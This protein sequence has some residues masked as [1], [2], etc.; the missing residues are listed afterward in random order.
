MDLDVSIRRSFK[1]R[2]VFKQ[3]TLIDGGSTLCVINRTLAEQLISLSV[4]LLEI[5]EGRA[6]MVE[7]G[8]AK[9]VEY[10]GHYITIPTKHPAQPRRWVPLRYYIPPVDLCIPIIIGDSARRKLGMATFVKLDRIEE[11]M[12]DDEKGND[13]DTVRTKVSIVPMD[14]AKI[15]LKFDHHADRE[16]MGLD[17]KLD[18]SLLD[19]MSTGNRQRAQQPLPS[20]DLQ[21]EDDWIVNHA[22]GAEL[23]DLSELN[24]KS[25]ATHVREEMKDVLKAVFEDYGL[26]AANRF[27]DI[28]LN[29]YACLSEHKFDFGTFKGI[30][31]SIPMKKEWNGQPMHRRPYNSHSPED[32]RWAK[33]WCEQLVELGILEPY[34][35]PWGQPGFV[36]TNNDGSKRL[37]I[38]YGPVNQMTQP[39][40]YPCPDINQVVLG[41]QGM[42]C[43]SQFDICK[44]FYN[45]ETE[46]EDKEK[47]AFVM[48]FGAYVWNVMSLGGSRPPATWAMQLT[49]LSEECPELPSTLTT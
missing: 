10:D 41:F 1:D 31:Y 2:T 35:G 34:Y 47:T 14:K 13:G 27:K 40:S 7:N 19:Q 49:W 22:E 25:V 12:D 39:L 42:D 24:G 6:F 44:A 15:T 38:D 5:H 29:Y 16:L 32:L 37:V 23:M 4:N 3:R 20:Q 30:K 33:E 48:P 26:K 36:V 18:E 28:L 45:V 17:E 46:D 21:R 43:L 11:I 9:D 8:S